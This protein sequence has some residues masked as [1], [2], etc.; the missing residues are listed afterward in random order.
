MQHAGKRRPP[1]REQCGQSRGSRSQTR[2][3]AGSATGAATTDEGMNTPAK[4]P[5]R[6]GK[7]SSIARVALVNVRGT[8]SLAAMTTRA[9]NPAM[10]VGRYHAVCERTQTRTAWP[11]EIATP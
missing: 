7:P 11:R 1:T 4:R 10:P 2:R 3:R 9:A 6:G 8:P 5:S